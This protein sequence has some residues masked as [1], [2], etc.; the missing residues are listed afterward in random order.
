MIMKITARLLRSKGAC[1]DQV[2]IFVKEWPEGAEVTLPN[3]LRAAELG[4]D[5]DWAADN[6]LSL[7]ANS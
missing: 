5:F 4:L 2:A 6:L 1:P 3:C 7:D